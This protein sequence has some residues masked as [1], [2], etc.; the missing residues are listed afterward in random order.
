MIQG[1]FRAKKA[2]NMQ[3]M[4]GSRTGVRLALRNQVV[5]PLV[6]VGREVRRSA[7]HPAALHTIKVQHLLRLPFTDD[8]CPRNRSRAQ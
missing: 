1:I 2:N 6:A 8:R 4:M 5:V 3:G 7:P